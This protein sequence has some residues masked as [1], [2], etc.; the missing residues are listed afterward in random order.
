MARV[1]EDDFTKIQAD[2]VSICL[3]YVEERADKV[4]VYYA[5][6]LGMVYCDYFF[7]IHGKI[8]HRH[9]LNTVLAENE[10]EYD[11]SASLQSQ[12]LDIL[13][14]DANKLEK[15]FEQNN[16]KPPMEI[17]MVYDVHSHAFEAKVRYD[18]ICTEKN[19]KSPISLFYEWYEE[20]EKASV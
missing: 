16:R 6:E 3:E 11:V 7:Q 14:R 5:D 1:F 12:V 15:L 4:F 17:R 2:M 18:S 8:V 13:L 20:M 10:P 9:K 19:G